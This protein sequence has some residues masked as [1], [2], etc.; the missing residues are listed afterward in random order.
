MKLGSLQALITATVCFFLNRYLSL[1]FAIPSFSCYLISATTVCQVLFFVQSPQPIS[2]HHLYCIYTLSHY[3]SLFYSI[4]TP[5]QSPT[6]NLNICYLAPINSWPTFCLSSLSP[7]MWCSSFSPW[8]QF[9]C[10]LTVDVVVG[11]FGPEVRST[12]QGSTGRP[13]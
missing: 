7:S 12:V 5:L 2:N 11:Q 1:S 9:L 6:I 4:M 3:C 10:S 13:S 8:G